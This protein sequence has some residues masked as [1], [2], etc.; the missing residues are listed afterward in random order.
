MLAPGGVAQSGGGNAGGVGLATQGTTGA[1][2]AADEQD[3]VTGLR[4]GA[5]WAR[6]VFCEQAH[7]ATYAWACRLTRDPE[8][9]R[10]WTHDALLHLM[11]DV[12]AG[13]FTWRRPGCFWAWFRARAPYL[14][15]DS[16]RARRRLEAREI[17]DGDGTIEPAAADDPA[18]DLENLEI[19]SAVVACLES[20]ANEDQ[21]Q[22]LTL[23]L[24]E[25]SSYEEIAAALGRPLNT[26]RTDIRRGRLA[27]RECLARTLELDP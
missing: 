23:L 6:R 22:A 15:L 25:E 13:R 4:T 24:Y 1:R 8:L 21:R 2:A 16:L 10:D 17:R 12:A 14:L 5:P 27:L 11:D 20:L 7:D 3:L 9:R 26:V 18:L 19:V